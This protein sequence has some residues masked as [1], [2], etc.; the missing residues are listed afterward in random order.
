MRI[1]MPRRIAVVLVALGLLASLAVAFDR[2]R[3]E[4]QN[5]SVEVTMDQ[6][7]LVQFAQAHGY[8]LDEL[9]REMRRA[10][11]TSVAVYEEQ[12]QRVNDGSSAY[13]QSGQQ[14]INAARTSPLGD[15]M[16][17]AMVRNK[18]ID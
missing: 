8:D 15:P 12:G 13:V 11:L 9:L 1:S 17:A 7:D 16:L 2:W 3:Y 10:G 14:I 4:A 6:Q 5:R 18:S